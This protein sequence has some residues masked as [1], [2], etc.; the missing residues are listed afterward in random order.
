MDSLG[1]LYDNT[2]RDWKRLL[3]FLFTPNVSIEH[4]TM[5]ER[6]LAMARTAPGASTNAPAYNSTH[7]EMR[8]LSW[9]VVA[10]CLPP[11]QVD[12]IERAP[13]FQSSWHSIGIG[14][15]NHVTTRVHPSIHCSVKTNSQVLSDR[16]LARRSLIKD[17]AQRFFSYIL[18]IVARAMGHGRMR[19]V[20][21]RGI[22]VNFRR[23]WSFESTDVENWKF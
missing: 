21:H 5:R 8:A 7:D 11:P 2:A 6:E 10:A 19:T 18:Q 12:R 23:R 14:I 13:I 15:F 3:R 20:S 16:P 1:S 17:F 4:P 22:I 9:L